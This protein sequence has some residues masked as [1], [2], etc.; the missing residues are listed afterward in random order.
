MNAGIRAALAHG[1]DAVVLLNNDM[2]VDPGFVE[3]LVEQ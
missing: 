2:V 1:A 3:P